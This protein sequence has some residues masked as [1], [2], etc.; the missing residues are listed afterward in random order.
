VSSNYGVYVIANSV[1]DKLYVGKTTIGFDERWKA[2]A[3]GARSSS[4]H[5]NYNT[6]FKRAIRR[7]GADKFYRVAWIHFEN[8]DR[9]DD[10]EKSLISRLETHNPRKGYNMTFGGDG[11]PQTLETRAKMSKAHKGKPLSPE[12]RAALKIAANRPEVRAKTVATLK[13]LPPWN[14]GKTFAPESPFG[15]AS[16]ANIVRA[17]AADA[18]TGRTHKPES[19]YKMTVAKLGRSQDPEMAAKR[20]AKSHH[21]RYHVNRNIS[22]PDCAFCT[23]AAAQIQSAAKAA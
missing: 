11:V 21:T 8:E 23:A 6:Y 16:R 20:L 9:L 19:L 1:N 15:V 14:R 10:W 5:P 13:K 3:R 22:K 17:Q 4:A 2:H 12:H 18:W 7:Y